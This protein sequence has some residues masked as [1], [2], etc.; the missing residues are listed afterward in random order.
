MAKNPLSVKL[1]SY[2]FLSS[3]NP[4]FMLRSEKLRR[5][6]YWFKLLEGRGGSVNN[7]IAATG[8]NGTVPDKLITLSVRAT[9]MM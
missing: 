8:V 9:L 5:I 6:C 7:D 3:A 2:V 1:Y 4:N